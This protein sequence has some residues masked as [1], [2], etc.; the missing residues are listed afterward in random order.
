MRQVATWHRF[1]SWWTALLF[2]CVFLVYVV[3]FSPWLTLSRVVV[4]GLAD[5]DRV[6]VTDRVRD[7]LANRP[8]YTMSRRALF[9]P[10]Q[11]I[12]A[13]VAGMPEVASVQEVRYHWY[14]GVLTVSVEPALPRFVFAL[15]DQSYVVYESGKAVQA[16][17]PAASLK[18]QVVTLPPEARVILERQSM[19]LTARTANVLS[20]LRR[21]LLA[22]YNPTVVA[23]A[24]EPV[25][26]TPP[27]STPPVIVAVDD[28][29]PLVAT[30]PAATPLVV[31]PTLEQKN[32]AVPITAATLEARI[33]VDPT[34]SYRLI[35]DIQREPAE[36]ID[37]LQQLLL[38]LGSER[39]GQLAYIDLR[40]ANKAFV[41]LRSAPCATPAP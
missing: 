19:L 21:G 40:I 14:T 29:A 24:I 13:A 10:T 16:P 20:G 18:L 37:E 11:A 7:V 3:L 36:A 38:G 23:W 1:V 8:W 39:I 5:S 33:T 34:Y 12:T 28:A 9:L 6:V 17:A 31:P 27:Q 4:T 35:F 26:Y 2:V 22:L 32:I 41:C 15:D 25:D 30:E